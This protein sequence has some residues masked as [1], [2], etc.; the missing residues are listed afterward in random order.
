MCKYTMRILHCDRVGGPPH[1]SC[2]QHGMLQCTFNPVSEKIQSIE[3]AFDVMNFMQQ[4]QVS[5]FLRCF[6][7][8]F[9]CKWSVP[10]LCVSPSL[11]AT[12]LNNDSLP[13]LH[14]L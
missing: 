3:F 13:R 8:G 9:V 14:S 1:S 10:H 4:L 11:V 12:L 5:A 2:V 7:C 6:P